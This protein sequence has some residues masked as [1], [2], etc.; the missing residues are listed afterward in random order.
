MPKTFDVWYSTFNF[1]TEIFDNNKKHLQETTSA[2]N[3]DRNNMITNAT[4]KFLVISRKKVLKLNVHG[5]TV[6]QLDLIWYKRN[7]KKLKSVRTQMES[8]NRILLVLLHFQWNVHAKLMLSSYTGHIL[9]LLLSYKQ[10]LWKCD[11]I[12]LAITACLFSSKFQSNWP[13][14]SW[15]K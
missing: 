14:H 4:V 5:F 3:D 6:W 15:I 9:S 13:Q 8:L 11:F 2:W 12:Q 7:F 1:N 10:N